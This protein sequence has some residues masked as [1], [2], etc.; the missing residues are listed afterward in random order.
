MTGYEVLQTAVADAQSVLNAEKA[1]LVSLQNDS[2]FIYYKGILADPR[3][4]SNPNGW[5]SGTGEFWQ[6]GD[7]TTSHSNA[8]GYVNNHN[9]K[10]A[11]Q[12][13]II[14]DATETLNLA[15]KAL[16][17]YESTSP[18]GQQAAIASKD[19]SA[20]RTLIV[21]VVIIAVVVVAISFVIY[22]V[23]KSKKAKTAT[24]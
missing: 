8:T 4:S 22:F 14:V 6:G 19:A 7:A 17:D 24:S 15:R 11:A 18:I 21:T 13:G 3:V 1:K 23:R 10:I 16:A 20:K 2:N 9:G 5:I 12:Q